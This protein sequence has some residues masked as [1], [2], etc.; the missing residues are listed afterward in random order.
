MGRDQAEAVEAEQE[1]A[2]REEDA[3]DL[4]P[5]DPQPD[6]GAE[7]APG[8]RRRGRDLDEGP[9]GQRPGEQG[10]REGQAARDPRARLKRGRRAASALSAT[11]AATQDGGQDAR[12]AAR[13]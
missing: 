5:E 6:F 9:Q 4:L 1:E 8:A 2:D 7:G 10:D 11:M 12:P 3:R 13:T